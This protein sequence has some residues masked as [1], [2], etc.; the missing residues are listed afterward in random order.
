VV[1]QLLI[2]LLASSYFF[3]ENFFDTFG[4][5]FLVLVIA[6]CGFILLGMFIGYIFKNEETSTLGAIAAAS[7]MLFF[8]NTILPI[9]TLPETIRKIVNFNP[10]VLAEG[11]FKKLV[12]F[13]A[14]IGAVTSSILYLVCFVV[15]FFVLAFLAREIAKSRLA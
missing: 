2:L 7:L 9:E 1:V 12:L 11:A 3:G 14:D 4:S 6:S 15:I 13:G 5:A 8:S 10:F